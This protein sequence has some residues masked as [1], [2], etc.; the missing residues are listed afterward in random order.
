MLLSRRIKYT[1][2]KGGTFTTQVDNLFI[3]ILDYLFCFLIFDLIKSTKEMP[4]HPPAA[5]GSPMFIEVKLHH[6]LAFAESDI[7]HKPTTSI[8]LYFSLSVPWKVRIIILTR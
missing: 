4:R 5:Y 1:A 6:A 3:S 7:S 8:E 2:P